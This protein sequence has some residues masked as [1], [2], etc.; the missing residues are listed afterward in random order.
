[1]EKEIGVRVITNQEEQFYRMLKAHYE[2]RINE[3]PKEDYKAVKFLK[4]SYKK[5]ANILYTR[6]IGTYL[7]DK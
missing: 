5:V 7:T 6:C 4:K 1:M 2:E 3:T